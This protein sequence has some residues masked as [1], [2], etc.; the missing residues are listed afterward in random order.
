MKK[1][2]ALLAVVLAVVSCQ[3]DVDVD[4]NLSGDLATISVTLPADAITRAAAE[5]TNSAW[6]GL[7]NEDNES[8]TV[9]LYIFDENGNPSDKPLTAT[10]A[11][12]NLVAN[13]DVRLVPG[14][15]YTFVAWAGQNV[16]NPHFDIT[17][18]KQNELIIAL[19]DWAAM[20]E[21]RDAFTGILPVQQF[22]STKSIP[23]LELT[24]P[25]AKLRVVTTDM[26]WINNINVTP[27]YATVT[28]EVTLPETFNAFKETIGTDVFENKTH[29]KFKIK[30]YT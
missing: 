25:F 18:T 17:S 23:T 14:R 15:D 22:S 5:D 12:G 16:E 30:D 4:V 26:E 7:Q 8:L 11:E 28:Y 29:N 20:D 13:F 1:F 27:A 6:S 9:T 24:R 19:N 2:F 10:L 21:S 3:K